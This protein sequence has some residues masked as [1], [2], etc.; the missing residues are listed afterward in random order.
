M[1]YRADGMRDDIERAAS[2]D[3]AAVIAELDKLGQ[4]FQGHSDVSARLLLNHNTEFV[5]VWDDI[6]A[7]RDDLHA[8]ANRLEN[9]TQAMATTADIEDA[10]AE[11][12]DVVAE[13]TATPFDPRPE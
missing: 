9:A 2:G 1:T 12:R 5:R 13:A 11:L 6:A 7:V 4:A 8:V 10:K 3:M